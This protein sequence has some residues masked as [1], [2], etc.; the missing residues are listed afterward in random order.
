M[1]LSQPP[2][3]ESSNVLLLLLLLL[4]PPYLQGKTLELGGGST[5]SLAP[6]ITWLPI[7]QQVSSLQSLW[8]GI[9]Y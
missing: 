6:S 7:H 3:D 8:S 9:K 1:Q 5:A 4:S 2:S